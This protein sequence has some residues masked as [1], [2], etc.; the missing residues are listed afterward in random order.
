MYIVDVITP[1]NLKFVCVLSARP[2]LLHPSI[3]LLFILVS[4]LFFSPLW[5][6]SLMP[7][8]MIF[9]LT[10]KLVQW[11]NNI[12]RIQDDECTKVLAIPFISSS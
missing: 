8:D 4:V 1:T 10:L 12:I 9:P 5:G 3:S 6:N 7:S 2:S 11:H